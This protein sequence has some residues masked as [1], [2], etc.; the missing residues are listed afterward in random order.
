MCAKVVTISLLLLFSAGCGSESDPTSFDDEIGTQ[1]PPYV[2]R[3]DPSN[4]N[5]GDTITIF[6]FGFSS[7]PANNTVQFGTEAISALTYDLVLPPAPGEIEKITFVIPDG[8][9]AATS[10]LAVTVFENT[11]NTNVQMTI[12]P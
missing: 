9:Q 11:S 8:T 12:D 10:S 3:I 4:G 7:V 1:S 2:N 5:A 6:G